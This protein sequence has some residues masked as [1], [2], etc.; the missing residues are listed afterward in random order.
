MLTSTV[1]EE[2]DPAEMFVGLATLIVEG[3]VPG[4]GRGYG[5]GPHCPSPAASACR[6][7]CDPRAFLCKR[8]ENLRKH[9]L[10]LW[11]SG[12][13][14]CIEVLLCPDCPCGAARASSPDVA[15]PPPAPTPTTHP[16]PQSCSSN[17][18]STSDLLLLEQWT[19]SVIHHRTM[20]SNAPGTKPVLGSSGM[21]GSVGR[22]YLGLRELFQAVR[23]QLH[24]SQ[25]GAWWS[26]SGG[27]SPSHVVYRLSV[28]TGM[29][30]ASSF[31]LPPSIHHFPKASLGRGS[32][33]L[34]VSLSSLPRMESVP[35]LTCPLHLREDS[36]KEKEGVV[37]VKD[38][39]AVAPD[40]AV[41][42]PREE[43]PRASKEENSNCSPGR[44][45]TDGRSGSGGRRR[46]QCQRWGGAANLSP[47]ANSPLLP[48]PLLGESLLDP[49]PWERRG[50]IHGPGHLPP[51]PPTSH[52]TPLPSTTTQFLRDIPFAGKNI[53][54]PHNVDQGSPDAWVKN[55]PSP[56][57]RQSSPH[58][59]DNRI[60]LSSPS[61]T[62][63]LSRQGLA[64]RRDLPTLNS[65][66]KGRNRCHGSPPYPS[67]SFVVDDRMRMPC[68]RPGKHHCRHAE[69]DEEDGEEGGGERNRGC[70]VLGDRKERCRAKDCKDKCKDSGENEGEREGSCEA[71]KKPSMHLSQKEVEEVLEALRY[72]NG[73]RRHR[74]RNGEDEEEDDGA[75]GASPL[76]AKGPSVP[77]P[78]HFPMPYV[79]Q[80]ATEENLNAISKMS[81]LQMKEKSYSKDRVLGNS[82]CQ[83][84]TE[85]GSPATVSTPP[86]TKGCAE[87]STNF[88]HKS[89]QEGEKSEVDDLHPPRES[90]SPVQCGSN[91][92]GGRP[93][94][95]AREKARFR[96]SLDSAASMVFHCRTGLPLT[97][98]P[99]PIRRGTRFDFDS[100]LNSVS[101]I[102]SA[103]F[104]S[105][106]RSEENEEEAESGS[107]PQ[108]P[109]TPSILPNCPLEEKR[110]PLE[111]P[112]VVEY[113]SGDNTVSHL[114]SNNLRSVRGPRLLLPSGAPS[115][116]SASLLGSFEES[117]LNG[118]LEPVSTVQGFTAEI[119]ASGPTGCPK[120]LV[121]PVTVFFYTLGDN[122]K[123]S[124][125]YLS[126]INLG[127][128]G[129]SVPR[130]G[131]VQV[132]LFNPL[133][134]VVK[135]FVVLYDLADMPPLSQT[136][137]RQRT[138]YVPASSSE[139]FSRPGSTEAHK[140]LRYLIHLRFSS[141][142][143][144]RIYLHTD[145]RMIIFRK[146]DL[147]TATASSTYEEAYEL[148]S[149]THGP[150]NP[151]F[152][153]IK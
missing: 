105:G 8:G 153:P 129:Y 142:K 62:S 84:D 55:C 131:T 66:P 104:E 51:P 125:P 92:P 98:S 89:L 127:R 46:Q 80:L 16:I 94:P 6:H 95:S 137:L 54:P 135:M 75:R 29:L 91:V 33:T 10:L 122:D 86:S 114:N 57:S 3:R 37:V 88:H 13:P 82:L 72:R 38:D 35:H 12:V 25:L 130:S 100:S 139:D 7:E 58:L 43:G 93:V 133:G 1:V 47:S 73:T 149:F 18:P 110:P 120:H 26:S 52:R 60:N 15:S 14:L 121:V 5:E 65:T 124:T 30:M 146:S 119:G 56:S 69:E 136:F 49:P 74:K 101:A 152:S 22:H 111:S 67:L 63:R 108:T 126:H 145:I 32:S 19:L 50:P 132:T 45:W 96:K 9:A 71:N 41:S 2:M 97:S 11:R 28:P 141:S 53:T 17:L 90:L 39:V 113:I 103:L 151:K 87:D 148:R 31:V 150:T 78:I 109:P 102:R 23:S 77:P 83:N 118:R 123:V 106:E 68:N 147:D 44:C 81:S 134:T 21:I 107:P 36:W 143:S 99:A 115:P 144:G 76:C 140:W 42:A 20:D 70:D 61:G 112:T 128:K 79:Y 64:R 59:S 40:A 24:F 116:T 4:G 34:E 85:V 138:L 117:V 48:E 27:L